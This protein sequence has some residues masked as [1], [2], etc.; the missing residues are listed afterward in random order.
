MHKAYSIICGVGVRSQL[1]RPHW[2]VVWSSRSCAA[3]IPHARSQLRQPHWRPCGIRARAQT[4]IHPRTANPPNLIGA[5]CG[6]RARAQPTFSRRAVNF[7]NLV[8]APCRVRALDPHHP[9][10]RRER[11]AFWR[12]FEMLEI[13]LRLLKRGGPQMGVQRANTPWTSVCK[14]FLPPPRRATLFPQFTP[15]R[16]TSPPFLLTTETCHP[17]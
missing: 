10:P 7:A 16:A 12:F 5:P 2:R 13:V 15:T 11:A 17:F 8:G 1:P 14:P 9:H 4:T 6:L 3:N